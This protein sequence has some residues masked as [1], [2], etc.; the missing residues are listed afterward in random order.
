[1]LRTS[2]F[3]CRSSISTWCADCASRIVAVQPA[4][5]APITITAA[6]MGS[7]SGRVAR[8]YVARQLG[9]PFA[10]WTEARSIFVGRFGV[11]FDFCIGERKVEQVGDRLRHVPG[12]V[13]AELE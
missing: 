7:P 8:G 5:P 1:M 2:A 3:S 11:A 10:H 6:F 4:G 12:T 13:D 9:A